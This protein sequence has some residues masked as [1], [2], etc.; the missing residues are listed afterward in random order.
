MQP[1][2]ILEE[3]QVLHLIESISQKYGFEFKHYA[4]ASFRRRVSTVLLARGLDSV[5]ALEEVIMSCPLAFRDFVHGVSVNV[6]SMFRDPGFYRAFRKEVVPMLATYPFIRV[7]VAGC[8]TGEEVYSV[9]ITLHEAGL[10]ERTR[11]YATDMDT[12][13]L[14]KARAGIYPITSIK[15]YSSNYIHSGGRSSLSSYYSADS[16]N[17]LF[18]KFL[19]KNIVFSQ[20]N[21]VCDGSFNEF[22]LVLCRNVI[23]YF[24]NQLRQKVLSLLHDSLVQFGYLGL[25]SKESIR[26]SEIEA[27]YENLGAERLYR[28]IV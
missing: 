10:L 1:V 5:E 14:E 12:I 20:H 17:A 21:L 8:S 4:P 26:F 11:I 13:S 25:G 23:I 24:D 18:R 7:W 3:E 22:H 19:S 28:R 9:A 6:T 27:C 15:D 16:Q 2:H